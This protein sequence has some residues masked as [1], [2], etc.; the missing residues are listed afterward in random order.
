MSSIRAPIRWMSSNLLNTK[1]N[2]FSLYRAQEEIGGRRV[3]L[4]ME[5]KMKSFQQL[6]YF[7]V[8]SGTYCATSEV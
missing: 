6:L 3:V 8:H 7:Y 2:Q 5:R 1:V 4:K